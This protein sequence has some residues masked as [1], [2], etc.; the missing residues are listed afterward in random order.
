MELTTQDSLF[1]VLNR[2]RMVC[3]SNVIVCLIRHVPTDCNHDSR[4]KS[5][6]LGCTS[7]STTQMITLSHFTPITKCITITSYM[8][9]TVHVTDGGLIHTETP[10][11]SLRCT[12]PH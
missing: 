12:H 5:D 7:H 11:S 1:E 6:D 9:A 3:E 4:L 10:I 2:L 8:L